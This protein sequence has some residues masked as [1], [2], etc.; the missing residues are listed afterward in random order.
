[1][2]D[3]AMEAWEERQRKRRGMEPPATPGPISAS[4]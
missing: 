2:A 1:M 4:S 3:P